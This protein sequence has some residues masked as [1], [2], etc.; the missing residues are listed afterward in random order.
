MKL[1]AKI[2]K[3]MDENIMDYLED[4]NAFF[5]MLSETID[6][7]VDS[8]QSILS[9]VL[10]FFATSF[11]AANQ[12]NEFTSFLLDYVAIVGTGNKIVRGMKED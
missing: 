12:I 2:L 7:S 4:P 3:D 5:R 10:G 8:I 6:V 1:P 9:M 11:F